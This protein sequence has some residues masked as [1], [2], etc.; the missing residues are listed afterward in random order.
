VIVL[1]GDIGG[2]NSRLALYETMGGEGP[3]SKRT[4]APIYERTY[5]SAGHSSL[6]EIAEIFL[7]TASEE[8]SGRV[9]R[10]VGI[11]R[12][13]LG[14]AG[15][16]ENNICRATNLPWV[17]DGRAVEARLG[18]ARVQLVNDFYAA[19]SAVTAVA[20]DA[21][22][23]LG[24][25]PP[26]PQGPIAVL[27][28]GTGLGQAFL[29]WSPSTNRYQVVPSEGGHMDFAPRT[30]L[31][32]GLLQ[33]L[34][35]KYGRV[36]CERVLSGQGLVDVF[37]FLA[38]EPACRSLIRP[39]TAAALAVPAPGHDPAAAISER[40]LSGAD[41]ICEMA[42]AMFCTVMG[43]VAGN[44]ALAVLAT[45][46]VY[47]AG[48]I[49]PRVLPYLQRGVF[50]ETFERKGRMH[51]LVEHIPVFVVTHP[52]VGLLGAATIASQD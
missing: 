6:D 51:T 20:P 4:V 50:R 2:T 3:D 32:A 25:G 15:P 41:P 29:L 43:A 48:G 7:L 5:P 14:V 17:V 44:L 35:S 42:L 19:A 38:Q 34:T 23:A 26:V 13:C 8:L 28:A 49:A 31:E 40:A 36:S 30:P 39:E 45:G 47:V 18:I 12:A 46:G 24:G 21:L 9:G 27:G 37:G 22:V 11:A 10:G 33:F 16:I 1:A 52:Q